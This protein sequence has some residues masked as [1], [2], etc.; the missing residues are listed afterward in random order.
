MKKIFKVFFVFFATLVYG[1]TALNIIAITTISYSA[2]TTLLN[3]SDKDS[4]N[5]IT[6]V[7]TVSLGAT[8]SSPTNTTEQ[9][10]ESIL[11]RQYMN[12]YKSKYILTKA[13]LKECDKDKNAEVCYKYARIFN[14]L[15]YEEE[16]KKYYDLSCKYG[17]DIACGVD[18]QEDLKRKN[19]TNYLKEYSLKDD[20]QVYDE[21]KASDEKSIY[22][23]KFMSKI[24]EKSIW[25]D[26]KHMGVGACYAN[27]EYMLEN[28][29][30]EGIRYYKYALCLYGYKKYCDRFLDKDKIKLTD[31][32]LYKLHLKIIMDNVD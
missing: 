28:N 9:L 11:K 30:E 22:C 19:T 16:A 2:Y 3:L 13:S 31:M 8:T 12:K 25:W 18:M 24:E 26:D 29:N 21:V 4:R 6:G 23:G 20:I 5:I 7:A 27:Y 10:G 1:S 14:L 17:L 15:K 32:S